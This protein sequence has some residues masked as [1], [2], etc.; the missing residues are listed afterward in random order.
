[1]PTPAH[2]TANTRL[3]QAGSAIST[4]IPG[5][6]VIL[7][8]VSGRYFGLDGVGVRVWEL[9]SETTTLEA[10][11]RTIVDEYEADASTCERDLRALLEDLLARGLVVLADARR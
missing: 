5:E 8:P 7:D 10:L 2:I 6:A 9:L 11:V 4:L 1:M 3:A